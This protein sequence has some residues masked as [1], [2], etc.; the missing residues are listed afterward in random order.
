MTRRTAERSRQTKLSIAMSLL[1][2]HPSFPGA[3]VQIHEQ[4]KALIG[5]R[6]LEELA[7][8]T[9]ARMELALGIF[10]I[11]SKA[12][13]DLVADIKSQEAYMTIL[14]EFARAVWE[15]Y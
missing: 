2:V 11:R 12:Y 14:G 13:L 9:D 7:P 8:G 15:Q 6:S 4:T 10:D 3:Q 1:K 5:D